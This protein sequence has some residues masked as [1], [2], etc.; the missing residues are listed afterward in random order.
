[1]NNQNTAEYILLTNIEK[2]ISVLQCSGCL[3]SLN[4]MSISIAVDICRTTIYFEKLLDE[5]QKCLP[6][7]NAYDVNFA[8][9][10]NKVWEFMNQI[11]NVY[12][13]S[14][15]SVNI[16]EYEAESYIEFKALQ[17]LIGPIDDSLFHSEKIKGADIPS[18]LIC[19]LRE[20]N[21]VMM[22][23]LEFLNS[24]TEELIKVS[25]ERWFDCYKMH[26]R[27]K[28]RRAYQRWK[29]AYSPRTLKKFLEDRKQNILK[30]FRDLFLNDEE[31]EQVYDSEHQDIDYDGLSRF[32]FTHADRFGVSF[33]DTKP[34]FSL[35]LLKLFNIVENL[36][37][38]EADLQHKKKPAE[39]DKVNTVSKEDELEEKIYALLEK[40]RYLVAD[41]WREHLQGL[42]KK[43]YR[44][45]KTDIS[46]AG[47]HEKFKEYSKKTIYCIVGHLKK[48][49]VYRKDVSNVEV[50]KALE[51]VNNGMR[52]YVNNGLA[53]LEEDLA[54]R[55]TDF[56]SEELQKVA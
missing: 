33:I 49:G 38:V 46:K 1:M 23:I 45:F 21:E 48:K 11:K 42:W 20:L 41:E 50:T 26:Y 43:I 37:L 7:G 14:N 16:F 30:D 24:P 31:L 47:P 53:E 19:A 4:T 36:R 34:M 44:K 52:K 13:L 3:L 55:L 5:W 56:I 10:G 35:E 2:K 8:L 12:S 15:V 32:L 54:G 22:E 25:Y 40:V 27:N 28:C 18:I 6:L 17:Q 39:K 51:G 29:I 9:W